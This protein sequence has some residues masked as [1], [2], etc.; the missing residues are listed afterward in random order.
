MRV[1]LLL[2][3]LA[4]LSPATV[5]TQ[6]F[7]LRVAEFNKVWTTF[8]TRYAGCP[9]IPQGPVT[10]VSHVECDYSLGSVDRKAFS[11]AREEAKRLFQLGERR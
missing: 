6:E 9:T 2:V 7:G 8:I 1:V 10:A 5:S 11:K 4:A 3:M